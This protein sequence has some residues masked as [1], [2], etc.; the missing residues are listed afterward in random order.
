MSRLTLN[1]V[2]DLTSVQ[3]SVRRFVQHTLR[4]EL[5]RRMADLKIVDVCLDVHASP[6]LLPNVHRCRVDEPIIPSDCDV[7][8]AFDVLGHLDAASLTRLAKAVRM[9][10]KPFYAFTISLP[11]VVALEYVEREMRSGEMTVCLTFDV[12]GTPYFEKFDRRLVVARADG[13]FV[14][15]VTAFTIASFFERAERELAGAGERAQYM[16]QV[17]EM[18]VKQ[19][20]EDMKELTRMALD[21]A[22]FHS[23][24]RTV[25]YSTFVLTL[26]R[27]LL[28]FRKLLRGKDDKYSESALMDVYHETIRAA[29]RDVRVE[30]R[31]AHI[32]G[33]NREVRQKFHLL[34][35]YDA[36]GEGACLVSVTRA[37]P[38]TF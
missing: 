29:F 32:P 3:N 21:P 33:R 24:V 18:L 37:S 27:S 12:Y 30:N 23:R 1:L 26:V 7:V 9:S 6:Q 14:V 20:A 19:D 15:G 11:R 4:T 8:L 16:P 35:G 2:D 22:H 34:H 13:S 28:M 17:L 10:K 5:A 36:D 31:I 38:V 25:P